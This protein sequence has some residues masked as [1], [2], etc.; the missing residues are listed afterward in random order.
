MPP[1]GFGKTQ[2]LQ[3]SQLLQIP[4]NLPVSSSSESTWAVGDDFS[5]PM[6]FAEGHRSISNSSQ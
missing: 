6:I 2:V 5:F 3:L 1:S 4:M